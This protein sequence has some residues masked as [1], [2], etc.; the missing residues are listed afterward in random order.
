ID[1]NAIGDRLELRQVFLD[2]AGIDRNVRPERVLAATEWRIGNTVELFAR[3]ERRSRHLDRCSEPCPGSDD[4]CRRKRK[5]RGR[6]THR[7]CPFPDRSCPNTLRLS[8]HGHGAKRAQEPARIDA[9]CPV[10]DTWER[11]QRRTTL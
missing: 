1:A 9:Q 3:P 7:Q 2:L 6:Q 8:R 5:E 10:T 11:W 4:C